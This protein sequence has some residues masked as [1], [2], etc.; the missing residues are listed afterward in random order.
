MKN[1]G[2]I[3]LWL[4]D[5]VVNGWYAQG[6][7]GSGRGRP[8][9]YSDSMI[10]CAL[11]LRCIFNLGL[12]QTQGFIESI[13]EIL[14]VSVQCASYTTFS[15][16]SGDLLASIQKKLS[17]IDFT[18]PLDICVDSSG[19][20]IY[21][22]GEWKRK[23]HGKSGRRGWRKLHIAS[24]DDGRIVSQIVTTN[25][26]GDDGTLPDLL[27]GIEQKQA[28]AVVR[29]DGAYDKAPCYDAIVPSV[30]PEQTFRLMLMLKS[31]TT[32]L[33]IHPLPYAMKQ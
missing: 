24:T 30:V 18:K 21:G 12:R 20:K 31:V 16:R 6:C 15:R 32:F 17:D 19:L 29:A 10:E 22:E 3:R 11:A 33:L 14:Q 27:D 1:R 7:S 23:K 2:N 26:C 8:Y 5:D 9:I 13:L 4:S 25:A 28:I